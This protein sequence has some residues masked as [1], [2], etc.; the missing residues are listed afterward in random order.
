MEKTSRRPCR[1]Y[2]RQQHRPGVP[3]GVFPRPA[4]RGA[5]LDLEGG[6]SDGART[7]E[8]SV[9]RGALDAVDLEMGVEGGTMLGYG[10]NS[11]RTE[12]L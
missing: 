9:D 3:G 12:L 5:G 6:V 11:A 1:G 10:M 4:S 8:V 2:G 7:P